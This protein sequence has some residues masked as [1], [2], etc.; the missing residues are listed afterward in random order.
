MQKDSARGVEDSFASAHKAS[1]VRQSKDLAAQKA[2]ERRATGVRSQMMQSNFLSMTREDL[3]EKFIKEQT[4]APPVG[5]YR[6]RYDVSD[7]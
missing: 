6:C 3:Y 1:A 4:R 5:S 7:K 2:D